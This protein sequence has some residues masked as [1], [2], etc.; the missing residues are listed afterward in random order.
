VARF[1]DQAHP[2]QLDAPLDEVKT[3]AALAATAVP[4]FARAL[5]IPSPAS[6]TFE[7]QGDRV[8]VL[9]LHAA[10]LVTV[11]RS[12]AGQAQPVQV[13]VARILGELL[14]HEARY[15]R[16]TAAMA[17]LTDDG[18]VLKPV[19]ATAAL[20]SATGLEE[21]AAVAGRVPDLAEADAG[22]LRQWG[23]WLYGLYPA[24][25]GGDLGSLQPDLVA[26]THVTAE[27][28][29]DPA[30]ARAC[31]SGLGPVQAV[32]ALTVLARACAHRD[33]APEVIAT[34]L[35][36]DLAN[37]AIP[38]AMVAVQTG[39]GMGRLLEAALRD[40]PIT[41]D[42]LEA[43]ASALPY[44]SVALAGVALAAFVRI[45]QLLPSDAKPEVVAWW[46]ALASIRAQELGRP[47]DALPDAQEALAIRRELAEANPDLYRPNLA[48]SLSNLSSI[49]AQLGRPADA[50]L[51]TQEAVDVYRELADASPDLYR[52]PLATALSNLGLWLAMLDGPAEALP[53]TEEALAI[54]RQ[55][56]EGNSDLYR[57]DLAQS[58]S[59]LGI[60]LAELGRPAEALPVAQEAVAIFEQLADASP[61]RYQP[62]L[63]L[64]LNHLG[65][66]LWE[67][68]RPAEALAIAEEAV[69]ILEQ[70][71]DAIA[72]RYRPDLAEYLDKLGRWFADLGLLNE[73]LQVGSEAATIRRELAVANPKV[74]RPELAV[75]LI[76]VGNLLAATGR[77]AEALRAAEEA[78]AIRRELAAANPDY[79]RPYL[80]I[81][82]SNLGG[83]LTEL[84]RHAE[85]LLV[86]EEAVAIMKGLT[87]DSLDHY[88]SYLAG[89]LNNLAEIL[90]RLNRDSEAE[91]V[92][93]EATAIATMS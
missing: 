65:T 42:R 3:D 79:Y 72:D 32:Q 14:E 58:L 62:D 82:L 35:R 15:W 5:D 50:L 76:N 4:F 77:V 70:L 71:A 91:T 51:V 78:A 45:R 20:L 2:V 81:A 7:L 38:A 61:D 74:Y 27:L 66:R 9:V 26:E 40:A 68:G 31:L 10:A 80:A 67:L 17:G 18:R 73:A 55:L 44:P 19:V 47:A 28:S 83:Y 93:A 63:A 29:A 56:A 12:A 23:R 39:N 57:F 16:R 88:H 53:A 43:I 41:L 59:N 87:P 92:Q 13:T 8:P 52:P 25:P 60:R 48:Q 34:V 11:L 54:R 22:T 89:S 21:A 33:D 24:E 36:A 90:R 86:A 75:S 64:A 46:I 84:G 37:L 49:L 1:L 6:V 85:A 30:L 69:A